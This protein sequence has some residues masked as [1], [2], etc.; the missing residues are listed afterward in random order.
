M[1]SFCLHIQY[2]CENLIETEK[3]NIFQKINA[4]NLIDT[5]D[6]RQHNKSIKQRI[7]KRENSIRENQCPQ[8]GDNLI[9][10]NGK[11]GKFLG[12]ESY[13]QCKFIRNI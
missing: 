6:K 2:S 3:E 11:F 4:L 13:P 5:Y 9:V 7:Q 8:C 10:R 1:C 12:C